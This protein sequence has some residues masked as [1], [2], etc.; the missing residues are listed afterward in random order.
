MARVKR[1]LITGLARAL[2]YGWKGGLIPRRLALGGIGFLL[3]L[4]TSGGVSCVRT[5]YEPLMN[6]GPYVKE[7]FANPNP[8][9]GA[10]TVRVE[11][12]LVDEVWDEGSDFGPGVAGAKLFLDS[13]GYEGNGIPMLPSDGQFGSDSEWVYLN[14]DVSAYQPGA[15][16]I[17]VRG[18]DLDYEWGYPDSLDIEITE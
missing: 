6:E 18:W 1:K 10:D 12:L 16:R 5:C 7:L 14:V 13:L 3:S 4:G 2:L 17:Y 9:G 15:L 11:A 8:T